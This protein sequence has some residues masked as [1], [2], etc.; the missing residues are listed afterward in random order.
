MAEGA[1]GLGQEEV[2]VGGQ[3]GATIGMTMFIWK[4]LKR[5]SYF[6][7]YNQF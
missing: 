4:F 1:E 5:Q 6:I 2:K 7:H 3:I